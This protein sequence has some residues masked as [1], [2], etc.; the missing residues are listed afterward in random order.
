ME[1]PKQ[2]QP[3]SAAITAT[4]LTGEGTMRRV[5]LNISS[6]MIKLS[7]A[8]WEEEKRL[9]PQSFCRREVFF[10]LTP[11]KIVLLSKSFQGECWNEG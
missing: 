7:H 5:N 8:L 9:C 2:E 1:T 4:S 6:S 10:P 11:P 3:P